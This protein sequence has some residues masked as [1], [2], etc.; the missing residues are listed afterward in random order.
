M[1]T[2]IKDVYPTK[3]VVLVHSRWQLLNRFHEGLHKVAVNQ[4]EALGIE[5]VLGDRAIIPQDGFPSEE[6]AFEIILQS[7]KKIS[8]DFAVGSQMPRLRKH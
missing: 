3:H 4:C 8:A 7:G 2:D 5:L 6:G 1:A